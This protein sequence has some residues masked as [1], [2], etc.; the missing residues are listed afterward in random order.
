[1]MILLWFILAAGAL[2]YIQSRVFKRMVLKRLRYTR[3]FRQKHAFCGDEVELVEELRNEKWLPVPWLR[4]EALLP[5]SLRFGKSDNFDV[6]SGEFYQNHRS[7]FS[8]SPF[9]KVTRTHKI[10]T[11]RRGIFKLETV[12]LTSGDL[13]GNGEKSKVIPIESELIVYPLPILPETGELPYHSWQ[14]EHSVKRYI[15]P[16]PFVI[17]GTRPY[18][19]GDTMRAVNWKASARTGEL[20]VHQYDFTADTEL[21]IY[22]N[23]ESGEGM[24]RAVTNEALIEIGIGWAAGAANRAIAGGMSAGLAAN[25]PRPGTFDSVHV[26]TSGGQEHLYAMLEVLAGLRLERS[27]AFLDLLSRAVEDG[28]IGQDMLMI[29]SYWNESLEQAAFRLRQNGNTVTVWLL[30]GEVAADA[31]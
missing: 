3:H 2:L 22:L 23:V 19:S 7:F 13:L 20:Q 28:V 21:M 26:K 31:G 30:E 15:A 10:K 4:A 24:W 8:L 17:A 14:G 18:R 9:T 27:E 6:S 1:M 12:T 25:M 11:A 16:D 29:T 5:S